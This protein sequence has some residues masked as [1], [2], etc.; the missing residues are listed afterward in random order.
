MRHVR[1]LL[2]VLA[3]VTVLL[4]PTLA[5]ADCSGAGDCQYEDPLGQTTK[6]KPAATETPRTAQAPTS[7]GQAPASGTASGATTSSSTSTTAPRSG[8]AQTATGASS[9]K[10]SDLPRTGTDARLPAALG[11]LCLLLG[12]GLLVCVRRGDHSS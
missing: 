9:R 10:L 1:L 11:G 3:G 12:V 8:A 2:A 7:T 5:V 6:P 4:S